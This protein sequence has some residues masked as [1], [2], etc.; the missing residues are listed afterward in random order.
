M[1][2]A[3]MAMQIKRS[4]CLLIKRKNLQHLCMD[5]GCSL[6]YLPDA[7]DDKDEWGEKVSSKSLL[8]AHHHDKYL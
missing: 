3:S 6:S 8:A 7:M 1:A 4:I 2:F 5:R